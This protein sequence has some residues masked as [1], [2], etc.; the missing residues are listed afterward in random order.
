MVVPMD[1]A[2]GQTY[3]G[4]H[5]NNMKSRLGGSEVRLLEVLAYLAAIIVVVVVPVGRGWNF[6][7]LI[8]LIMLAVVYAVLRDV[9]ALA[10]LK[11]QNEQ[12]QSSETTILFRKSLPRGGGSQHHTQRI[13]WR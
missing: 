12:T 2:S 8:A 10:R 4:P 6:N 1:G 9:R 13:S 5:R 3:P 11:T 7:L